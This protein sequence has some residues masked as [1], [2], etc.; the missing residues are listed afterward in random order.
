MTPINVSTSLP[1]TRRLSFPILAFLAALAV[2]L[3]LFLPGGP[4]RAQ[5]AGPILYAENGT[6]PV[7]VF[8]STDPEGKN[9]TRDIDWDVTGVDADDFMIRDD[10]GN[11]WL[12][13]RESPDFETPTDRAGEA[14]DPTDNLYQVTVRATEQSGYTGRALS[15][16]RDITVEVTNVNEDGAVEIEWRQ[17]QVDVEIRAFLTDPDGDLTDVAWTWTVSKVANPDPN[18]ETHWEAFNGA[19]GSP[20]T[21]GARAIST[22]TPAAG[23]SPDTT[24]V[25]KMLRATVTYTAGE[26][27]ET[28]RAVSEFPVRAVPTTTHNPSLDV[29]PSVINNLPENTPVGMGVG[30]RVSATDDDDD[31]IGKFTYTLM[32]AADAADA[33]DVDYFDI[34][35]ATGRITVAQPLDFDPIAGNDGPE[36]TIRVSVTDPS[37]NVDEL[38]LTIN[39]IQANDDPVLAGAAE[40][41]VNE[42]TDG[43][44]YEGVPGL[45]VTEPLPGAVDSARYMATDD[46]EIHQITWNLEGEDAR[47][48]QLTDTSIQNDQNAVRLQFRLEP[49]SDFGPPNYEAPND[50]NGDDV[51]KVIVV[52]TDEVGGRDERPVT[53]FVDNI[54]EP[55]KLELLT[56]EPLVDGKLDPVTGQEITA[57][58]ADPDEGVAIVTWQWLHQVLPADATPPYEAIPGAT[59]N[60]YTPV[61]PDEGRYLRVVATYTDTTSCVDDPDTDH[62][63]RWRWERAQRRLWRLR[64]LSQK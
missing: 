27:M 42:M 10:N 28:V 33:D 36:Y 32:A 35:K 6:E 50:A 44:E 5:E 58:V 45:P 63:E 61:K 17:P 47:F 31:D 30:G 64:I 2:G 8:T 12:T 53:V 39:V 26:M 1:I 56:D 3:L 29:S 34:N 54:Y 49:E 46:D 43:S 57:A 25:D 9:P 22:Y 13:F 55:G 40:L 52:A 48:F 19:V 23:T 59:S 14:I 16:E 11:G 37:G 21:D 18:T 38:P 51:Y 24:D 60:T 20:E 15:T 4:A 7:R 62:D 41:R